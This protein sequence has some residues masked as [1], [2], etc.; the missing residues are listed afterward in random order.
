MELNTH[1]KIIKER[2]PVLQQTELRD[3]RER[4]QTHTHTTR[5]QHQLL[6]DLDAVAAF[7]VCFVCA[8]LL[9]LLLLF[10]YLG[11]VIS[12]AVDTP[13]NNV[14]SAT[15]KKRR[16]TPRKHIVCVAMSTIA[17]KTEQEMGMK[18]ECILCVD[19]MKR[20]HTQ[21]RNR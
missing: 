9:L 19:E 2:L 5:S 20:I 15:A 6:V 4:E 14:A 16:K 17:H 8:C 7:V 12:F 1:C 21:R 3:E 11:F 13:F 18:S 10:L